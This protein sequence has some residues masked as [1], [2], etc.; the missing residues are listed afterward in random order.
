[1]GLHMFKTIAIA[2]LGM[3]EAAKIPLHH[4]PLSFDRLM[5]YRA[6]LDDPQAYAAT[7]GDQTPI[8][9][10]DYMNTQYFV[11][12]TIGT[13]PQE[14][15]VVPD[16]G[17]SNLWVYAHECHSIPCMTH[18]TF[19][20][21]KSST[22][23]KDGQDFV[24]QYGSGGV[25]GIVDQDDAALGSGTA[26]MSFGAVN[27]VSGPTFYVSKMD[28]IIGLAYNTISVDKLPTFVDSMDI[29][30]KSFSFY[31]KNNPE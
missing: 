27:K 30:D 18:D 2:C 19:N 15:L 4:K 8:P 24:I 7:Y 28:G 22:Y 31:L 16:T 9:L 13:P 5:S 21:S 3:V 17:S 12:I 10:K 29:D 1:M 26:M 6:R 25:T 11:N 14:F 23:K 20:A